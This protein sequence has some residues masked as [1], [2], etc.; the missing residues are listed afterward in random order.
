[1]SYHAQEFAEAIRTA[2]AG[3]T[4]SFTPTIVM[5]GDLSHYPE[6]SNVLADLPAIFVESVSWEAEP[7]DVGA[8]AIH[9]QADYRITVIDKWTETDDLHALR[10]GRVKAIW[11]LFMGSSTSTLDLAGSVVAGTI[12]WTA[13]PFRAR[14]MDLPEETVL[15]NGGVRQ[16][17]AVD[18]WV[19]VDGESQR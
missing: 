9:W 5:V 1:M 11:D 6:A 10:T 19:R 3:A 8:T 15:A 4:L 18:V 16:I 7:M 17:F 2:I 12:G 14:V 13:L